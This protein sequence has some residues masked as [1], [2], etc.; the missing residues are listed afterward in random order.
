MMRTKIFF[1]DLD[2]TLLNTEKQI[3]PDTYAAL[4]EWH[5]AGNL[6]AISSGRPLISI[7]QVIKEQKLEGF[8][9]FAVAFNGSQIYSCREKR[10]IIRKNI[11][12]DEVWEVSRTAK[13]IGLHCH[14][15]D[16]EGILTPAI[17]EEIK[18]YTRVVKLPIRV[19]PQ[20]P[21]GLIDPPC[22]MLCIDLTES[23]KLDEMISLI[24]RDSLTT[25]RSNPRY[26]EVFNSTAGKGAAVR[27][28]ADHLG[29]D[30][31]GTFAAGDEENDMSMIEAAGCGVA[32]CN[33]NPLIFDK[34]DVVTDRDN[35]HDGLADIIRRN[36]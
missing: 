3:T 33:G 24:K 13:S 10:D 27:E 25:I 32:M 5:D 26:L 12:L 17:N 34:A 7:L 16:S 29:I 6:I 30:I 31:T 20:F 22:K 23:G 9:P 21:E 36:I 18:Y 2:G 35:D 14:S 8:D 4:L 1:F 15:Y 19:L 11:S 28:L